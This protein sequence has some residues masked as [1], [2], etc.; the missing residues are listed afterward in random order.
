M[1]VLVFGMTDTAGGVESV[2]MNYYRH[3]DR[4][5]IQFDFLCNNDTVAYSDEIESM[6]GKIIHIPMRSKDPK[7]YK[8]AMDSFFSQHASEYGAIWVNVCSLAN[9][10]YLSYAKKYGIPKRVIH[11]HNSENMDSRLRGLLHKFNRTRIQKLATDYWACSQEAADWFFPSK[12]QKSDKFWLVNNAI[13][14]NKFAYNP[15]KREEV[16]KRMGVADQFVVGNV[17]RLHFQ[18]NQEFLLLIFQEI[19]KRKPDSV[20]W[21]IG[22]GEDEARLRAQIKQMGLEDKA[23]LLLERSDIPDLLSAMDVFVM[24]SRFEGL[25]LAAVEAQAASLPCFLSAKV[26]TETVKMTDYLDFI[27][28]DE[29]PAVWAEKIVNAPDDRTKLDPSQI[30]HKGFSIE[31]EVSKLEHHF[32]S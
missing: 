15:Y 14:L 16:R 6:G 22:K 11:S 20:L 27:G 9:V 17:G 1:K 13:D 28:L 10:D 32:I 12:L 7:G 3:L 18:K 30:A 31:Q 8:A 29:S 24:P 19:L 25:S 4:S 5:K 21:M 2:I 26:I 23:N